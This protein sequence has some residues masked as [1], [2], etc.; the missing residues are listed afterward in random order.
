MGHTCA[1][2]DGTGQHGFEGNGRVEIAESGMGAAEC[3]R[4]CAE[5]GSVGCCESRAFG[6]S[7]G[8]CNFK[9]GGFV[10]YHPG[11]WADTK[12]VACA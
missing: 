7:P 9:D 12:A 11:H 1:S 2:A 6:S 10:S 8:G 3:A 4:S 5:L